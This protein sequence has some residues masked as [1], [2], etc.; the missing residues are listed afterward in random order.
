MTIEFYSERA[1]QI[2]DI[3]SKTSI[4]YF[5]NPILFG[6]LIPSYLIPLM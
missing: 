5:P 2:H 4:M 3:I 1:I 6:K